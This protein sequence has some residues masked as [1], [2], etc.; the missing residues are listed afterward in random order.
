MASPCNGT[1][2]V[3]GKFCPQCGG[4]PHANTD[5]AEVRRRTIGQEVQR[6][7]ETTAAV[8]S[9]TMSVIVRHPLG[10]VPA[11]VEPV[12]QAMPYYKPA[13]AGGPAYAATWTLTVLRREAGE[14]EYKL[15]HASG[16]E[17]GSYRLVLY[18]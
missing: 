9:G 8:F 12:W 14:I 5:C 1:G 17:P 18:G 10:R 15:E 7:F 2:L 6:I 16:A 4:N 3:A 13:M 11:H